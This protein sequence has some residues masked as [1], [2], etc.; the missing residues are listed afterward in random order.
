VAYTFAG[1]FTLTAGVD[2]I[3]DVYPDP[4]SQGNATTAG[5]SNFG[6]LRYNQHSPFGFNGAFYYGRV[7]VGF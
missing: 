4:N 1:R 7:T 2:N 6:I 5:N 3:F